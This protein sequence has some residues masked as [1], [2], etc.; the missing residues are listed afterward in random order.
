MSLLFIGLYCYF[1]A[2]VFQM[3]LKI[4][5]FN[6]WVIF[7]SFLKF[8]FQSNSFFFQLWLGLFATIFFP[9][10]QNVLSN[11]QFWIGNHLEMTS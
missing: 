9:I 8:E 6:N 10:L 5:S 11:S 1:S 3:I 4:L 2:T 7:H